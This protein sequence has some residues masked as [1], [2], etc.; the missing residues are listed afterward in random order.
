MDDDLDELFGDD[1]PLQLLEPI[2]KDLLQR[3][4]ESVLSGCCQYVPQ[5]LLAN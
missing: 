3:V 2:S 1:P 4:D 5:H